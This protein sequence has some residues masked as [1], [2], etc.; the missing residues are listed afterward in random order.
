[1]DLELEDDE[2]VPMTWEERRVWAYLV[3]VVV[4][5]GCYVALIGSRLTRQPAA[6]ISWVVPMLWTI[7]LSV[8]GTVLATIVG[9]IAGT[10]ISGITAGGALP[11]TEMSSDVR[12]REIGRRGSHASMVVIS[13]GFGVALVLAM[14]DA[15]TFWI[16]NALF[17]FGT[18]GALVETTTK[19]RLYRRGFA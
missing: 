9:T 8:V 17:L 5:S 19:I 11:M 2:R 13:V 18:L 6:E 7:G 4:T 14:I 3:T 1:M 12:D 16:G 10:I 15:D